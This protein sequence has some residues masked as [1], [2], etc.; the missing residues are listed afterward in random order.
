MP[1]K[2]KIVVTEDD[3][4]ESNNPTLTP[5]EESIARSALVKAG[6]L[7]HAMNGTEEKQKADLFW[8]IF[9]DL[10]DKERIFRDVESRGWLL[11]WEE[12]KKY[13]IET[14]LY[15]LALGFGLAVGLLLVITLI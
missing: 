15:A 7:P 2:Y 6:L 4:T 10:R 8:K 9:T 12:R 14:L 1:I 3:G 11:G 5:D 13:D